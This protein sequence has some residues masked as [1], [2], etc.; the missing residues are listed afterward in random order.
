MK[1][2]SK[3]TPNKPRSHEAL[4]AILHCKGKIL[5]HRNEPKGGAKNDMVEILEEYEQKKVKLLVF[6]DRDGVSYSK[7]KVCAH[8][9]YF[10]SDASR[11]KYGDCYDPANKEVANVTPTTGCDNWKERKNAESIVDVYSLENFAES[12]PAKF[13]IKDDNDDCEW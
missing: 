11:P 5:P 4:T 9:V 13:L 3:K 12:I 6:K 8:C 10:A 2:K 7:T 1:K